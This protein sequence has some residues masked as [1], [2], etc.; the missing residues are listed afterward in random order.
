ME[1]LIPGR[2][3]LHR[4][5]VIL[6]ND[7][8]KALPTTSIEI[9]PSPGLNKVLWVP[10][11]NG[12][13]M[14]ALNMKS[15]VAY[16]NLDGSAFLEFKYS[17][18]NFPTDYRN[19]TDISNILTSGDNELWILPIIGDPT[20]VSSE[21]LDSDFAGLGLS[22]FISNGVLGDLTGGNP[23]NF[24]RVTIFYTILDI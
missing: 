16:G 18:G 6:N 8:I 13:G 23:D 5:T 24:L 2:G 21:G 17:N 9:I 15:T 4:Q 7:Q 1:D 14:C 3:W 22:F 20:D 10:V 11:Q 12:L 19:T